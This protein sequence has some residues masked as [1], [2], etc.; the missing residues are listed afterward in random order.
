MSLTANE[1]AYMESLES[2]IPAGG[3]RTRFAPSP[4]GFMHLGNLRTAL[5]TY[6]LAKKAN[7]VFVLR[8][9]DTDQERLVDGAME[10][11][12][13]TLRTAGLTYDE[14][15]DV[16]G[17]V[18]PYIQSERREI[19][20]LYA[21]LLIER[22]NGY[23]CF[24]DKAILDEQRSIS[25]ASRVPHL[26]D[27][28][29]SFLTAEETAS[30]LAAMP[31]VIR[32]KTPSAGKTFFDD[33]VFGRVEVDNST[34]DDAVLL[35]SDGLPTYNFANV[36]DDH[37]M[38]I[39][40]VIRGSEYL[41]STPKYILLYE[42]FGWQIPEYIH[43]APIM[44]DATQKLSKRHGDA[45]FSDFVAKGYTVEA[46]LNYLALL[47]FSPGGEEEKFSLAELTK[48]FDIK[49]ISK[50]PSIFDQKNLNSLNGSYLRAMTSD[51]FHE[52]ALPYIKQG[53]KCDIDTAFAAA[54]LQKRCE[55]LGEI[56][57]LFDFFDEMPDFD[58]QLFFNKKMKVTPVL[59]EEH[60]Q[61]MIDVLTDINT[62]TAANIG[63]TLDRLIGQLEI[64][65]SVL[66]WPLRIALSGKEYTAGGGKEIC[67]L[68][69]KEKSVERLR[70]AIVKLADFTITPIIAAIE[71]APLVESNIE[72]ATD[73]DIAPA[74]TI[75]MM[76][77]TSAL[78]SVLADTNEEEKSAI[79][80][81]ITICA[82]NT[83]RAVA[84]VAKLNVGE[85][86]TLLSNSIKPIM[87]IL[88]RLIPMEFACE[89]I[90]LC[91]DVVNVF[92]EDI[93]L[94]QKTISRTEAL[95][96]REKHL[97]IAPETEAGCISVPKILG[98]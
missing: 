30:K 4:T 98:E 68:L 9:E 60:L 62:W 28:R 70:Q 36:V 33:L 27:R 67:Y 43:V 89:D 14:G 80:E 25:K 63:D 29:C 49:G 17:V 18:A 77:E 1:R 94:E 75:S 59:I 52:A 73:S 78:P 5:Y 81:N 82:N 32:Q 65:S 34:L 26:Y 92:R 10:L 79:E 46:L 35:K 48:V 72:T 69:G 91:L 22:G 20:Q 15:P 6:L 12:Y 42:G 40:H 13:E 8:I 83:I 66:L 44:K 97:D 2:R 88:D 47:G 55:V 19:Y 39:T 41:P 21:R 90:P 84:S 76:E 57:E 45:Y 86:T 61:A 64:K 38:G 23:Y 50:Y 3:L 95:L 37:L 54:V 87:D 16:G 71:K 74:A 53:V 7:G 24:C 11:I 96:E 58:P 56:P 51:D 85:D 31:Y 93:P